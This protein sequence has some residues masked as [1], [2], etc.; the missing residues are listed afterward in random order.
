VTINIAVLTS[1]ALVLSCDSIAS[2]TEY[3]VD[4]FTCHN[5]RTEDGSLSVTV[6]SADIIPQVTNTWDGVT[7]LFLLQGGSCP[8]AA[9]TA[10]LA[11]LNNRS[12][13]SYAN[14]F[15]SEHGGSAPVEALGTMSTFV[16]P[17][18]VKPVLHTV[19]DVA[20]EFLAFMR[21]HYD[22]HYGDS[23]VPQEYRHGPIFLVGG[24]DREEHLPSLYKVNV[25]EDIVH[26]LFAAGR[27]GLAWE[28]QTEAVERLVWGYDSLL[29][30]SIENQIA[31]AMESVRK[32]MG[33]AAASMLQQILDH[34]EISLPQDINT[35]L[36]AVPKIRI[37]WARYR[38]DIAYGN[39]PLQDAVDLA[40]F[41][42]SLQSGM[43]KF[44]M[45]VPTVGGRTRVGVVSRH[46]GFRMLGEPELR[47][48]HIGFVS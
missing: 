45:G 40:A 24:Y 39:L 41:L 8:V 23:N 7:K 15:L 11:K 36:P 16:G 28:G 4:P 26:Q 33:G 20:H 32:N 18:C 48:T 47:H 46:E 21:E 29:R 38:C 2:V 35:E 34:A 5:E 13:S 30:D 6:T 9:V 17:Q 3:F 44:A 22:I 14:Q 37:P 25:Q 42:V 27:F 1:E 43:S 19:D 31:A 10:G 12:M